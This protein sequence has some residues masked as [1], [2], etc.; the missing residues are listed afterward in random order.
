MGSGTG[1]REGTGIGQVSM[2]LSCLSPAS[3]QVGAS[4]WGMR[5]H[6]LS[7]GCPPVSH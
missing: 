3:D 5:S 7:C 2:A 1:H 6:S 4:V